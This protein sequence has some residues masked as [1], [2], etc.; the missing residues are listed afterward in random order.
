MPFDKRTERF[1]TEEY[2]LLSDRMKTY[3]KKNRTDLLPQIISQKQRKRNKNRKYVKIT[4]KDFEE[5][6]ATC[7]KL[8]LTRHSDSLHVNEDLHTETL[9]SL[10]ESKERYRDENKALKNEPLDLI[11]QSQKLGTPR[12]KDSFHNKSFGVNEILDRIPL[13]IEYEDGLIQWNEIIDAVKYDC[14]IFN[15]ENKLLF[16]TDD[17][18]TDNFI[19]VDTAISK[20]KIKGIYKPL[21]PFLSGEIK[22]EVKVYLSDEASKS[23]CLCGYTETKFI[24]F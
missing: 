22:V 18:Y 21:K 7:A 16:E 23:S 8:M 9:L 20:R 2:D 10:G 19:D 14:Q 1:T 6:Q 15:Y 12:S 11:K 17:E 4:V 5:Q 24:K 13:D 3:Y